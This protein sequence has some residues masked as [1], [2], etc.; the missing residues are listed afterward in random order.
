MK[1]MIP[2]RVQKT[3][4]EVREGGQGHEDFVYKCQF[5]TQ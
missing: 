1:L 2:R 4:R 3:N 5:S